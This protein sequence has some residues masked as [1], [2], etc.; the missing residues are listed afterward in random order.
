MI[1]YKDSVASGNDELLSDVYDI[2]EVDGVVW[3]VEAK[4]QQKMKFLFFFF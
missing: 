1:I 3:E 2:K 4:V